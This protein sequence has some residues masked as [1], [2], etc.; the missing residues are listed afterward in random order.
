[1]NRH[2]PPLDVLRYALWTGFGDYGR[3]LLQLILKRAGL[4]R[5]ARQLKR[6]LR[7]S[8]T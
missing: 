7:G 8:A 1:M 5:G 6:G 4:L 2:Y 3:Y